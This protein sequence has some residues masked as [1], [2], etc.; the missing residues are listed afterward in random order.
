MQRQS[1]VSTDAKTFDPECA[2]CQTADTAHLVMKETSHF[3]VVADHAPLLAGHTLIIPRRH[4][5]C[6]GE[7]PAE[8][9]SELISLKNEVAHFFNRYYAHPAYWEH[10]VFHQTVFH[11][12]LHCFPIGATLYSDKE[13]KHGKIISD[14]KDI[15][16][17]YSQRGNYFYLEDVHAA[18]LFPPDNSVYSE[19]VKNFLGPA[20][21]TYST[22]T[23]W[24]TSQERQIDGKPLIAE[25]LQHWQEFQQ[26]EKNN[27]PG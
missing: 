21:A 3:R 13:V 9:D 2:F 1:S 14:Q 22:F 25:L 26:T 23:R 7:V 6:Y 11:A 27:I 8:L 10:G 4:Y 5:A 12:H 17:W 20:V 16:T 18:F 15:R 24:R 19:V